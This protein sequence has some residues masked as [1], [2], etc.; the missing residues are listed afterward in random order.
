MHQEPYVAHVGKKCLSQNKQLV[1]L[2]VERF[3]KMAQQKFYL[4][5]YVDRGM[6]KF[7]LKIVCSCIEGYHLSVQPY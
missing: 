4:I 3:E 5:R 2:P 7:S 1:N 6:F